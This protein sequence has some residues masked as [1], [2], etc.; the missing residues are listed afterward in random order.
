[1][2]NA[3]LTIS[4]H[5]SLSFANLARVCISFWH[6]SRISSSHSLFGLP[7]FPFPSIDPSII[8]FIFRSF[9][10]LHMCPNRLSFLL[11]TTCTRSS[12][13]SS[14]LLISLFLIL[15]NRFTCNIH[16]YLYISETNNAFLS[17]FFY[18]H[19][20]YAFS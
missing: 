3:Q 10:I 4:F 9:S 1:M 7:L 11:I 8:F 16:L 14:L 12:L 19:F 18:L 6:H 5:T 15:S 20:P 2:S 13:T 17:S